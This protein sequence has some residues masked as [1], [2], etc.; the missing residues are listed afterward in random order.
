[1]AGREAASIQRPYNWKRVEK[2][3]AG[4]RWFRYALLLLVLIVLGI[5]GAGGY[6][7]Y[8]M[9]APQGSAATSVPFIVR[10]GDTDAII[11][12]RLERAGI[13][14][15]PLL[16]RIDARLQGLGGSL[17]VGIHVLRRN[18]SIDQM[19]TALAAYK[20]TQISV[21]IPEGW[22]AG[23]IA[24]RLSEVGV[25]A[26]QF[27]HAVHRRRPNLGFPA[28]VPTHAHLEGFLSPNT[29]DITPGSAGGA[30]ADRLVRQFASTFTPAMRAQAKRL[31]RS[32]YDIVTLASI[33]EREAR[34]PSERPIIAS[35]YYNR[36][37]R[38]MIL[39]AD[40]TVQYALGRPSNW[41]PLLTVS[42]YHSVHSTYN[43]YLHRGLPPGPIANPGLASLQAALH[44]AHTP[45][46][47]FVAK[48]N[49][50]YHAFARTYQQQL[51]NERRYGH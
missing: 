23:Q 50:G 29:Y 39:Q 5:L 22:R 45:Y 9:H 31:G 1:M 35:V 25:S 17:R 41:W 42:D 2:P 37:S 46:L 4:M 38:G 40:P 36:L 47:Y 28:G 33:I 44:P 11:A 18:M 51:Q 19:V 8:K 6:V 34:A 27:L 13:L 43:T 24:H 7:Y 16:F 15:D 14:H 20:V 30:F 26:A 3:R 49:T 21:T 10:P 32:I 12:T 48:G